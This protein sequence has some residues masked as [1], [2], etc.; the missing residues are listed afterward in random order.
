MPFCASQIFDT[1]IKKVTVKF[2]VLLLLSTSANAT[3]S[4]KLFQ[5]ELQQRFA[6]AVILMDSDV[7]TFGIHDFDP[8]DWFNLENEE[9]GT[10]ESVSLRNRIQV[11]T[12][13]YTIDLSNDEDIHKHSVMFRLSGLVSEKRIKINNLESGDLNKDRIIAGYAAYKYKHAINEKW[14]VEPAFAVH[15]MHYDNEFDYRSDILTNAKPLLDGVYLNTSAWSLIY[16]PTINFKYERKKPWGSWHI[17]S[18]WHYFYG[19]GWGQANYGEIGNTEGWYVANGIQSIY[20]FD[21]WGKAVQSMYTRFSR[22]DLGA[23]IQQP[24][25]T[26]YYY[27]AS[28]G[29]L[30]TPPFDTDWVDNVGI[31]LNFNYGSALKGGSIVL[32]FNQQ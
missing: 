4:S 23:D 11:T 26:N 8:N 32:F 3:S 5:N 15:L 18:K 12:L 1:S 22:I 7:F 19:H 9:I 28:I 21:K 16:E 24:L 31:G 10:E 20:N 13:P 17:E 30:M 6:S 2:S 25:G 14:S 29:W 27:E